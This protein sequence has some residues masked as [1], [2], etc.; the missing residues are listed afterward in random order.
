MPTQDR[1]S[2][3]SLKPDW[4]ALGERGRNIFGSWE[5]ASIWWKHFGRDRP[6][7]IEAIPSRDG[8]L[9][10]IVPLYLASARPAGVVRFVGDGLGDELGMICARD[11]R[12][13]AASALAHTLKNAPWRWDVFLGE[14]CLGDVPWDSVPG[15][16]VLRHASSPT[17]RTDGLQWDEFLRSRSA[18]FR[19][20][21][22][23]FERRLHKEF[24]VRFRLAD[25]PDRL[26]GDLAALFRL[27]EA[28]WQGRSL[29]F[30]NR[31]AFHR[32]FADKAL[33][34]GWLRLW[35]LEL[36]GRTVAAQYGFR[37]AGIESYYQSG[38]EPSLGSRSIGFVLL[39]HTLKQALDDGVEEYRFLRGGDAYKRRFANEDSGVKTIGIGRGLLGKTALLGAAAVADFGPLRRVLRRFLP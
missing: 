25:D 4:I 11:E 20:Q 26:Q 14:N 17:L 13:A 6:L 37:F 5:W 21:A 23:R 35:F 24:D 15:T 39:I 12:S 22:L 3:E 33:Q 18:N 31:E 29:A 34:R 7:F 1:T 32:E 27:H 9:L 2:F 28:R 16:R 19:G 10:A 30:R 36:D 8:R 38:R